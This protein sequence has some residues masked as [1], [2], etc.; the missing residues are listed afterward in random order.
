MRAIIR[1]ITLSVWGLL[2]RKMARWKT[3]PLGPPTP[4]QVGRWFQE[5][6][7]SRCSHHVWHGGCGNKKLWRPSKHCWNGSFEL[8]RITGG[9]KVAWGRVICLFFYLLK[10]CVQL[11]V[12][13]FWYHGSTQG[14]VILAWYLT[15]LDIKTLRVTLLFFAVPFASNRC[16]QISHAMSFNKLPYLAPYGILLWS[17]GLPGQ[18]LN[19]LLYTVDIARKSSSVYY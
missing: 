14:L 7:Q 13:Q 15:W 8:G 17:H 2:Q 9:K 4:L 1:D 5:T 3:P 6:M 10:N 19:L 18:Y 16:H 11:E 12:D